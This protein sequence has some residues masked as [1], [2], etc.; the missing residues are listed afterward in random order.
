MRT[1]IFLGALALLSALA[2]SVP[3]DAVTINGVEYV[4]FAR[5]T[6]TMEQ[7]PVNITGNVGVNDFGGLLKVGAFN[8]INNGGL[9]TATAD[10]IKTPASAQISNCRFNN[11]DPD[12]A[13]VCGTTGAAVL[14]ITVWPLG[15][16][17]AQAPQATI[18]ACVDAALDENVP[19]NGALDLPAGSC[20]RNVVV[21]KNA[22]LTLHAGAAY[23]FK[24][25]RLDNG[26]TLEG[27]GALVHVQGL[28]NSNQNV[29]INDV[30]ITTVGSGF[31]AIVIGNSAILTNTI[32]HA[33]FATIHLH[34]G[35]NY[36]QGFEAIALVI[37]VEPITITDGDQPLVCACIGAVANGDT[38]ILLSDG[39][40]LNAPGNTFFVSTTCAIDATVSCPGASCFSTGAP[41][42]STDTT[43]T[44]NKPAVLAGDYHVIVV[45]TGGAF[46]TAATVPI[47]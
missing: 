14:P 40:H 8:V 4:L 26:A 28:V 11:N 37:R 27:N 45:N 2:F 34:T 33:P 41:T 44:L 43:A 15:G 17:I 42:A 36:S 7:G 1:R 31:E 9:S 10:S 22:T 39:C 29:K 12:L 16:Q 18:D 23:N 21:R 5:E 38:T 47:P 19:D 20:R 3:A 24:T 35:G 25:L 6:I 13:V 32:L 30:T 46:C